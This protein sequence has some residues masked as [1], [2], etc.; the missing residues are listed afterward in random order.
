MRIKPALYPTPKTSN[1]V[2]TVVFIDAGVENYQQLVNGVISTAEVFVL[3]AAAD[4][5]EQ[6]SQVLQQRQDV[7]TVHLISHGAPG[8]LYLGNT[9]LSLDTF[10]RYATQ[11]QQWNVVNLLLYGCNVAA[12][13]AG[14]EFLAKL[15][16]LTQA[17]IAASAS[18]I[19]HADLGGNWNLDVEIGAVNTSVAFT[20][21]LQ[22][23]YAGVFANEVYVVTQD[24]ES[25]ARNGVADGDFGKG[26]RVGPV[27]A[28]S[29]LHPIEFNI[30]TDA[31]APATGLSLL[32]LSI[33]DVDRAEGELDLV[34]I[35]GTEL[36]LLEGENELEFRTLFRVD[37]STLVTGENFVQIEID[38][39][40]DPTPW[41]AEIVKA[42]LVTNYQLGSTADSAISVS[43]G[44]DFPNYQPGELVNFNAEIDTTQPSQNLEL[45]TILR[46]PNGN[47]VEFD[48]RPESEN[49]TINGT[50]IDP[51]TW[52]VNLPA[53]APLGTWSFDISAFDNA[54]GNFQF[55]Q[56]QPFIVGNEV[57]EPAP[58]PEPTPAPGPAPGPEP[59]P[60]PGP[61]PGPEPTPAN[62]SSRWD[63]LTRDYN[64]DG[65][66]DIVV[67][68]K[69]GT[70]SGSTEVHIMDRANN[71]QSWLLQ[72][73]TVLHETGDNWDFVKGDYNSDGA[74][75]IL[76]IKKSST[77]SGK[78]EVHVMDAASK[79]QSWLTQTATILHETGD[80]WDFQAG[81][82]N[83]DGATDIL[84][85]KKSGTGSGSTEIHILDGA[86]NY[87]SWLMQTG[88][89]LHETGDSWN[90]Q[91]GDYNSDGNID[92]V[93]IKKS[94]TG[95]GSTEVHILDGASNYQSWLFQSGTALHETGDSWGFLLDDYNSGN[96]LGI[97]SLKESG[98]GTNTTETHILNQGANYQSWLLQSGTILHETGVSSLA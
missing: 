15:H 39:G 23:T 55:L 16:N 76:S 57:P 77:G 50:D 97:I 36:G 72:T 68:K 47:A 70:G 17:N 26:I 27:G 86:T 56:T 60:A 62:S 85:I 92:I 80:S 33:F 98:T 8:R 5:I 88:T 65:A 84:G 7:G 44:T 54:T 74:T 40:G 67:I 42:E 19:G 91:A 87:Q 22:T 79:Y 34:T 43:T 25:Q 31:N 82:Y 73:G 28:G 64:L 29:A 63:F 2:A 32:Y 71:Y 1:K 90:F 53:N 94:A 21:T 52:G 61:A 93:G 48:K 83:G 14:E 24:N 20:P 46:D 45:E 11:L 59:T 35:N 30:V 58:E 75:D 49:F 3:D 13:D 66:T 10:N 41:E 89:I 6:I 96:P 4:G 37:P 78:T 18:K 38:T 51:F 69:S 9:Q 95:S 12:G 81:D